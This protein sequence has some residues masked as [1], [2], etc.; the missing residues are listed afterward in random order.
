MKLRIDLLDHLMDEDI[1][2]A[3]EKNSHRYKP[4]PL[5]SK[6]GVGSLSSS[7][8]EQSAREAADSTASMEKLRKRA[9]SSGKPSGQPT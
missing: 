3:V 5:F 6:T 4:E 2:R 9:Q 1:L 7:S 8:T